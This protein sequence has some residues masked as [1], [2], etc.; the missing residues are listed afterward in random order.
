MGEVGVAGG[1]ERED[2][3]RSRVGAAGPGFHCCGGLGTEEYIGDSEDVDG[4][5]EL[6][7]TFFLEAISRAKVEP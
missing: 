6:R 1:G 4:S 7:Y 3:F 2:G 5:I